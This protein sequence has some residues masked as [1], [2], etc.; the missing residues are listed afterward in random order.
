MH[1]VLAQADLELLPTGN[2]GA[3]QVLAAFYLVLIATAL[4][5]LYVAARKVLIAFVDRRVDERK[6]A[7]RT[8]R[9]QQDSAT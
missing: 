1:L 8:V 5:G 7:G 3:W 6:D 9:E 2:P 4:V